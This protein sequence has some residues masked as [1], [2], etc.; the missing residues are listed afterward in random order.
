MKVG[1]VI[2]VLNN[3]HGALE[4]VN[5]IKTDHPHQIY[6]IEQ[7]KDQLP[8][9][10]A[11]NKGFNQAVKDGC[12]YI[13]I[14]NDD[15][16]FSPDSVNNTIL[17]LERLGEEVVLI[18]LNNIKGELE[19]PYSIL[20][21]EEPFAPGMVDDHPNYSCFMVRRDFFDKVGSFDENFNPAWCEDQ[22]SHQR[23]IA[24]GYRA[25]VTTAASCVHFGQVSTNLSGPPDSARSVNY[26]IKKW[27]SHNPSPPQSY[28]HPYNNSNLTPKEWVPNYEQ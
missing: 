11:W 22:D 27:G 15:I 20:S 16:L 13:F 17:E 18:S 23:I 7:W 8:L 24:L 2:P 6:I 12:D 21:K 5:S 1:F 4:L 14:L 10:G 9:A 28:S 19:D 3:Y 26:F 25:G